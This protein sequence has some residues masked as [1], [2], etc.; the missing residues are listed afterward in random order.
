MKN[1]I[2]STSAGALFLTVANTASAHDLPSVSSVFL[3]EML[4]AAPVLIGVSV[5]AVLVIRALKSR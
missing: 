3:H 4:H 5:V 1:T 2:S